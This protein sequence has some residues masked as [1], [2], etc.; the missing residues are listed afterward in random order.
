M[1]IVLDVNAYHVFFNP[2]HEKYREIQPVVDWVY[3]GSKKTCL[4]IGGSKF[5]KEINKMPKYSNALVELAR[6]RKLTR[7][8]DDLVDRDKDRIDRIQKSK[9]FDDAH[10][11][12]LFNVSGCRVFVSFDD[13][14]NRYIKSERYYTDDTRPPK[15]YKKRKH[16]RF[17]LRDRYIVVLSNAV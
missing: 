17:L 1:C 3:D 6:A 10:I 14:S 11:V 8:N 5:N 9:K 15:I 2:N 12:A 13:N 7:I 16:A 4:V